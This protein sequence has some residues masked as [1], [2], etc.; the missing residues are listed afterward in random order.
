MSMNQMTS[1]APTRSVYKNGK[2]IK[3]GHQKPGVRDVKD[4]VNT[5][6]MF[7]LLLS[8]D[9]KS[10]HIPNL[11]QGV[12][13]VQAISDYLK[14]IFNFTLGSMSDTLG[15]EVDQSKLRFCL[16]VPAVWTEKAKIIMREAAIEA[17]IV[18]PEDPQDRLLLVGEPEAAAL[19]C[20]T[21]MK[22]YELAH[23]DTFLICDAGGGTVDLVVYRIYDKDND[24]FLIEEVGGVGGL[25]GSV[26]LDEGYRNFVDKVVKELIGEPLNSVELDEIVKA[27]A[28][29]H[30]VRSLYYM[31]IFEQG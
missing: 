8:G 27:F 5:I 9:P 7:K 23:N 12:T 20:E 13:V 4:G 16:T 24:K 15:K 21:V 28:D 30:K 1:Q 22:Q 18:S 19:Y 31:C 10:E 25:C 11:P 6:S 17:G 3:W 29:G 14:A 2:L 26:K